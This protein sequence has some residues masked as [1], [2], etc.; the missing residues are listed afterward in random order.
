MSQERFQQPDPRTQAALDQLQELIRHRYPA[1]SFSV[2]RGEDPEGFYLKATVDL[3][4]VDEIVDQTL[5][6]RLFD[7]Q[8][9]QGLPVYVIPLQ[10]LKRVLQTKKTRQA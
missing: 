9:E 1:V 2:A 3:D 10:P 7:I 4:D 8:V 6:D 5:L